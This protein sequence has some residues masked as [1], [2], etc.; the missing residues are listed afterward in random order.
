MKTFHFFSCRDIK[1]TIITSTFELEMTSS[2]FFKFHKISAHHVT[3]QVSA[4]SDLNKK[5]WKICLFDHVFS[6]ALPH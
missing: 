6:Q 3:Y 5:F 4:S 2:I 1:I